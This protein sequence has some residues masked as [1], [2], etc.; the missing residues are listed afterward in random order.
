MYKGRSDPQHQ[1]QLEEQHAHQNILRVDSL[2]AS[3][4][5]FAENGVSRMVICR[6]TR[7]SFPH[8]QALAEDGM[9]SD[10]AWV[11]GVVL[12]F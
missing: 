8:G 5:C 1:H 12:L 3:C 9:D 2:V 4:V 11:E 6:V 10:T 7:C